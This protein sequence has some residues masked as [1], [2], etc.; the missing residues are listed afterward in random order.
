MAFKLKLPKRREHW[1]FVEVFFLTAG[2]VVVLLIITFIMSW[3]NDFATR[4]NLSVNMVFEEGARERGNRNIWLTAFDRVFNQD[5]LLGSSG[6]FVLSGNWTF[7]AIEARG[8]SVRSLRLNRRSMERFHVT[9]SNEAG[10][11]VL[12]IR[13]PDSLPVRVDLTGGFD[14]YIDL[15]E[16]GI[17]PGWAAEFILEFFSAEDVD[18]WIRWR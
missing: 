4:Q 1:D 10:Q 2:I 15:I 14:D 5:R 7:N 13:Q 9:S 8:Q 6:D 17:T 3:T 12:H 11:V 18:V 16:L